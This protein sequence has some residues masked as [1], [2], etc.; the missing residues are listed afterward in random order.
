MLSLHTHIHTYLYTPLSEVVLRIASQGSK[1]RKNMAG[2]G[3]FA[4]RKGR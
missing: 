3:H 2:F 4:E 1:N